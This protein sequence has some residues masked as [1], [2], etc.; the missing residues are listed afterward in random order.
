MTYIRVYE[1][2][3]NSHPLRTI[4]A[5]SHLEAILI[6]KLFL[7][8]EGK[9]FSDFYIGIVYRRRNEMPTPSEYRRK[10][11][12]FLARTD[13][14]CE[15]KSPALCNCEKCPCRELCEWLCENVKCISYVN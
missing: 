15:T 8:T 3:T 5:K 1:S 9:S 12:E 4:R 13:A 10:E 2:C 11:E 14:L 7:E 6:L